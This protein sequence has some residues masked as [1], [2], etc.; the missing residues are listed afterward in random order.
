MI[1]FSDRAAY[2]ASKGIRS[3]KGKASGE[4]AVGGSI[5]PVSAVLG[6]M[7]IVYPLPHTKGVA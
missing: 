2:L 6:R 5:P 4:T 1:T 7:F 3:L